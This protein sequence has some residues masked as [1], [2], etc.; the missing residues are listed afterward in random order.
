[1][2]RVLRSNWILMTKVR[3]LQDVDGDTGREYIMPSWS[4]QA[5]L[6]PIPTE[7]KLPI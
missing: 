1:M 2:G 7:Q 4:S 3:M 6:C 5:T